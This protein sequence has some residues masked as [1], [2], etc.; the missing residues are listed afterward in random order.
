GYTFGGA[1][2]T[3]AGLAA[4]GQGRWH[5]AGRLR[6]DVGSAT[7]SARGLLATR[8]DGN[9]SADYHDLAL[10]LGGGERWRWQLAAATGGHQAPA[11]TSH[12]AL[13]AADLAGDTGLVLPTASQPIRLALGAELRRLRLGGARIIARDLHATARVPLLQDR[14]AVESLELDLGLR[15]SWLAGRSEQL[16]HVA[17]RWEFFPGLAL[18]G[19]VARGI[20]DLATTS[21]TARSLGLF[22]SPA[23]VPGFVA[24][25]DW[26]RQAAGP[27]RIAAVDVAALWRGRLGSA[28][29]LTI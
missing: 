17:G 6:Q 13:L 18:R 22:L 9:D 11:A 7:L 20:D 25:I 26:R 28:T 23:F 4:T 29:Q 5:L 1:L 2:A 12:Q 15:Q 3:P 16:W 27:A 24:S 10:T 8:T 14:P 21:G 19:Q